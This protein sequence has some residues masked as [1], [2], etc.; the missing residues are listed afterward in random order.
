MPGKC[1]TLLRVSFTEWLGSLATGCMT[2]PVS[3]GQGCHD[4]AGSSSVLSSTEPLTFT[5]RL[6]PATKADLLWGRQVQLIDFLDAPTS[7]PRP[8]S[9]E[10]HRF[11]PLVHAYLRLGLLWRRGET[12][13][14]RLSFAER[15]TVLALL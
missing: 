15:P 11:E 4:F 12:C 13:F 10:A 8:G 5:C 6:D 2:N 1:G 9:R 7:A 14:C 3:E